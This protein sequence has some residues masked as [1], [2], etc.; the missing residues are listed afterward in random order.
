MSVGSDQSWTSDEK[1]R[2]DDLGLAS[3]V[4]VLTNIDDEHLRRLYSRA[5]AFVYPSLYEGFGIPL[6]EA[7]ACGFPVISSDIPSSREVAEDC[8]AYFDPT[9]AE[10]LRAVL[11]KVVTEG[12]DPNRRVAE[13]ARAES[14]SWNET[15]RQTLEVYRSL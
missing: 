15:A 4:Q 1:R 13:I 6:L 11:D 8:A 2:L 3:R 5:A 9:S 14:F 10:D 7:M 12:A